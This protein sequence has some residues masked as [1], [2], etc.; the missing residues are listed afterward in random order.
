MRR[1]VVATVLLGLSLAGTA[2]AKGPDRATVTGPGLE[3]PLV[4]TG[5]GPNGSEPLGVLTRAGGFWT[6]VFGGT[7]STAEP[8]AVLAGRPRG[9]LG[10][11]YL[12]VYR[13]PGAGRPSLVRQELYPYAARPVSH[14]APQPFWGSQ[15]APGGWYRWAP[16]LK[17]VLVELGLPA[18]ARTCAV[19][20]SPLRSQ[21]HG[22]SRLRVVLPAGG[23]LRV[24]R[25]EPDDRTFGTKLGWIPDRYRALRLS[26]SGRRLDAPGRMTVRRISWGHS[27]TGE[28]SWASA[29][30]FPA[31]GCWRLTGRAGTATVSY[32]VRVV[33]DAS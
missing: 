32:V 10:P 7:G 33:V 13:M 23:I 18:R 26:V 9:D 21:L 2:H 17:A 29:V 14:M 25:N 6:Q 19:T 22:G 15:R 16:G 1:L 20:T 27:S 11:R 12:A 8:G 30:S 28:G 24:Q 5:Y 4:V 31:G 3:R